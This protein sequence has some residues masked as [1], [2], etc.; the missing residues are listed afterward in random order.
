MFMKGNEPMKRKMLINGKWIEG[1]TTF[2]SIDPATEDVIGIS[3]S[4]NEGIVREAVDAANEAYGDWSKSSLWQRASFLKKMAGIIRERA[5]D[6]KRL[7]TLEMGKPQFESEIETYETADMIDFF[8]EEG[9]AYL[10]GETLPINSSVFPNKFSFTIEESVGVVGIIKPWNYPLEL[11]FWSIAPALLAGNT[12]IFKPSEYTPLIGIEIGKIAHAAE[13]PPGVLNVIPGDGVVGEQLVKSD[14]DMIAFTGSVET[15][16]KIMKNSSEKL[17]KLSLELG[18]SDPFIVCCSADIEEAANGALWGRFANCGQVCVSAKRIIL[19]E[20]IG[21]RFIDLFL[22]KVLALKIGNG[23]NPQTDLGPL[24]SEKQRQKVISQ[25]KDALDKGAELK[26]GGKIPSGFNKG[27]FYEP[28]VLLNLNEEMRVLNE[29]VFGPVAPLLTAKDMNNAIELANSTT[30][31]LGASVWTTDMDEMWTT[32]RKINA[33]MIWINEINVAYPNCPWGGVKQ[34]GFRKE[35]AKEGVLEY[36]NL[37]HV[38]VDYSK[39]ETR[40]WWFPYKKQ[41]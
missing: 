38:N 34:S 21:E 32:I 33:G 22:N 6:L 11:P 35:L 14:V 1:N 3:Y 25:V 13:L 9:K 31:G 2:E 12:I 37:K 36:T 7:I 27:F 4:A 30:F 26:C 40:D 8:A 20:E 15:G 28:T 19:L 29:E 5:G 24:V 17:H 18:G 10:T 39:N 16:K 23:L 41:A